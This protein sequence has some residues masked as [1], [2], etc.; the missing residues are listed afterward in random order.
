MALFTGCTTKHTHRQSVHIVTTLYDLIEAVLEE[1]RSDE[2]C[3]VT[4][5][6]QQLLK[7]CGAMH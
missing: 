3:L 1:V 4:P 5:V 7:D 2:Q 6:V